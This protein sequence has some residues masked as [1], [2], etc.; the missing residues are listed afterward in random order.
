MTVI[1]YPGPDELRIIYTVSGLTHTQRLN[2]DAVGS[3]APGTLFNAIELVMADGTLQTAQAVTDAW[4]ALLRPFF[5]TATTD[6][7]RAELWH[8][9]PESFSADYVS[10]Y[11]IA[12]AGSSGGTYVPAGQVIL[13]FRT[14]EGG[15]MKI[16][17]MESTVAA[18]ISLTPPYG[19]IN[20]ALANYVIDE[21]APFLGRDTSYPFANI[22]YHPG[23]NEAVFKRRF[24]QL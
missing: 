9:E 2:V 23:Q 10:A 1:N 6:F 18:G 16:A 11:D 17:L 13:T 5:S 12:L 22:A 14:T 3:P 7:V 4:V 21:N 8:Y 24:R 19:G 20:L 15:V